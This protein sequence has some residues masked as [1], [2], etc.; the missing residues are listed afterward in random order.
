MEEENKKRWNELP[1]EIRR[2]VRPER[3]DRF[4][5]IIILGS[6]PT[7]YYISNL[8]PPNERLNKYL[9]H[10]I[11][12]LTLKNLEYICCN[13]FEYTLMYKLFFNTLIDYYRDELILE[14]KKHKN[15]NV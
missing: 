14:F 11:N 10:M 6:E 15:T 12:Q 8:W 4:F 7:Y 2:R 3:L 9:N 1:I 13:H 5:N